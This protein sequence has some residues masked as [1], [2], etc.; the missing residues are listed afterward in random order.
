MEPVEAGLCTNSKPCKV[1]FDL[2]HKT[3]VLL[4]SVAILIIG[5]EPLDDVALPIMLN[6]LLMFITLLS[7][8]V[9]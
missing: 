9:P 5:L 2:L 7:L 4:E 8:V 3:A 1:I 6:S